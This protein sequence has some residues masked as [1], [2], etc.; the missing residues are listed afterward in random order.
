MSI[1][2]QIAEDKERKADYDKAW[3]QGQKI[4]EFTSNMVN[5]VYYT[6]ERHARQK[7]LR[8]LFMLSSEC[9]MKS[10]DNE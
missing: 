9:G 10:E 4:L 5:R 6:I 3:E 1:D 2:T 8:D 7:L